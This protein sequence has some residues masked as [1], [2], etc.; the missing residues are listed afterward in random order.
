MGYEMEKASKRELARKI[1][2]RYLKTEKAEKTRI[3]NEFVTN[4]GFN[5][6]YATRLLHSSLREKVKVKHVG[7]KKTYYGRVVEALLKIHQAYGEICSRRLQAILPE[8]ID[9]GKKT[10]YLNITEETEELLR[11]ISKST[12]DRCLK[13]YRIDHPQRG[14]S[15]TK[16]GTILKKNIQIHTNYGWDNK[17]PGFMEVDCVAHCGNSAEGTFFSSLSTVDIGTGWFEP[18]ILRN[19]TIPSLQ[20]AFEC[21]PMRLPFKLLGIDSDNGSEFINISIYEFCQEN[22]IAFTRSR[23]YQKND[24]AHIEERNGS[25][26]RR[27]LGY[28]RFYMEEHFALLQKY[29]ELLRI[30]VNFY[31]PIEKLISKEYLGKGR[32]LKKYDKPRPPFRR[33]LELE[34]TDIKT[35]ASLLCAFYANNPYSLRKQLDALRLKLFEISSFTRSY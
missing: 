18:F 33:I 31:I 24:Q 22:R 13:K 14:I 30:Y 34:S 16:P 12:I 5:R 2:E 10:G 35:R 19:K 28:N 1:Q 25:V 27:E 9:I 20:A 7:R 23:P 26:I 4:T 32:C 8:A 11:K 6:K 17:E 3:L 15:L 29:Y 21:L